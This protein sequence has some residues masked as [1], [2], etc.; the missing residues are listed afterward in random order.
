MTITPEEEAV[1]QNPELDA[2]IRLGLKESA[3]G[4]TTTMSFAEH[5]E[6]DEPDVS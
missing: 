4:K 6:E 3:E 5:L 1:L 2:G